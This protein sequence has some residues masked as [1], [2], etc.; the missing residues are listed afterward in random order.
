MNV[1]RCILANEQLV[2]FRIARTVLM[3]GFFE[4]V[5]VVDLIEIE[6]LFVAVRRAFVSKS[7]LMRLAA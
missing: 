6:I 5:Q 1:A 2:Y 7:S 4:K 3:G